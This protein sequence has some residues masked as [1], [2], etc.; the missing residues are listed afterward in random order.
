MQKYKYFP[1]N[2]PLCCS[3]D[4]I[5]LNDAHPTIKLYSCPVCSLIFKDPKVFPGPYEERDRYLLHKNSEMDSGYI[6]FLNSIIVPSLSLLNKESQVLDYGC[7]PV[8]VLS[9]LLREKGFQC[10]NYDPFFFNISLSQQYDFIFCTEC[11]EHFHNPKNEIERVLGLLKVGGHLAI[12]TEFYP[13]SKK[14]NDWYYLRDF[15][16]VVFYNLGT[17]EFIQKKFNL[18][19]IFSDYKRII[20]FRKERQN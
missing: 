12:M 7:G 13:E 5:Q 3:F 1:G 16:H 2:C 14:L 10:D 17:F 20:F 6:S 19:M 9:S 4:C 15:T 11:F 18:S 8:P